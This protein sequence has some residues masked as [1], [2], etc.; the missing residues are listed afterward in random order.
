MVYEPGDYQFMDFVKVG[1]PLT[2]LLGLI[3]VPLAAFLYPM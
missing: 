1:T 3:V 2:I